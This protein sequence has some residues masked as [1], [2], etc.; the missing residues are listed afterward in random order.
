MADDIDA[1]LRKKALE[2]AKHRLMES[3]QPQKRELTEAEAVEIVKRITKGERASEIIENALALYRPHVIPLFKKLAEL[4]TQGVIKELADHELYQIL[5]R[6]GF[7]V[8]VK[9]EVK[10]VRHGREY[11]I[12]ES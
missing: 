4:H 5:A 1:L 6:A 12:G 11:K 8:P 9:T 2:L 7:R 10:I 3:A